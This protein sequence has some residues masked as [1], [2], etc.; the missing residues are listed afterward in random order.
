MNDNGFVFDGES[1][2]TYQAIVAGILT[3]PENAEFLSIVME[4][5]QKLQQSVLDAI[6]LAVKA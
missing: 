3:R 1:F 2:E 6:A 5:K 4:R